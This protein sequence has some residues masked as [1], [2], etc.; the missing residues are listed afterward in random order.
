MVPG[1]RSQSIPVLPLSHPDPGPW[2]ERPMNK[3][4]SLVRDCRQA[5]LLFFVFQIDITEFLSKIRRGFANLQPVEKRLWSF[6]P[7]AKPFCDFLFFFA[8]SR[9]HFAIQR[10]HFRPAL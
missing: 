6:Q 7:D 1:S 9:F 5:S 4:A 3:V 10:N 2:P 8:L